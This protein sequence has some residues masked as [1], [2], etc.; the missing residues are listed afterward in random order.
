MHHPG[1]T[2]WLCAGRSRLLL[3]TMRL[4]NMLDWLLLWG[5][6]A[7][8]AL[9][10]LYILQKRL[11]YFVPNVLKPSFLK[12]GPRPPSGPLPGSPSPPPP[13]FAPVDWEAATSSP[14]PAPHAQ[15]ASP[16]QADA[17]SGGLLSH[18]LHEVDQE[19][20]Q[21]SVHVSRCV[22]PDC[23]QHARPELKQQ[24]QTAPAGPSHQA[25]LHQPSSERHSTHRSAAHLGALLTMLLPSRCLARPAQSTCAAPSQPPHGQHS[26][27][28]P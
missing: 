14:A 12:S 10:V 9:V 11:L 7:F 19:M 2:T 21:A 6:V 24:H 16:G 23:N 8:F 1:L 4:H 17:F 18:V 13:L 25:P 20:A 27:A 5:G 15:P 28:K 26:S 3:N 22:V